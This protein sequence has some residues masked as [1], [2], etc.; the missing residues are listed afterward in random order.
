MS[1][2]WELCMLTYPTDILSKGRKVIYTSTDMQKS[3]NTT[4][5]QNKDVSKLLAEGW[6]PFAADV[7]TL[8]FRRRV[9]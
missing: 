3:S 1:E 9:S 4:N 6:E 8:Y 2:Q 7:Y 5:E